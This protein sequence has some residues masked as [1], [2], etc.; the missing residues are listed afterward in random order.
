MP[1]ALRYDESRDCNFAIPALVCNI[2]PSV[3]TFKDF[4][5]LCYS[6]KLS[7]NCRSTISVSMSTDFR[8]QPL[9]L[10]NSFLL[11]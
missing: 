5:V 6:L 3:F 8:L 10:N 7:P 9:M 2:R 11:Y 4:V 1:T